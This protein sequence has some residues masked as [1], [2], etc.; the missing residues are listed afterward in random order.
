VGLAEN[1]E[2]CAPVIETSEHIAAA[3]K[4]MREENA[5]YLTAVMEGK[6]TDAYLAH[7]GANAPKFTDA[8]MKAIGSPIDFVGLNN[9]TTTW[10]RADSGPSGYAVVHAPKSYP[11]MMSSWLLV[12]PQGLYWGP[13][14]ISETWGVKEIYITENGASSTDTLTPDGHVYDSDR[15]MYL[16]NYLTQLYRGVSEGV[17]V[18]GYFCWSFMDNYEWADGYAYRFG[19]HYVDFKTQRRT[20]KLS[21]HF[22]KE[23]IARNGLA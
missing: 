15:V 2:A 18:K 16:R 20:P 8:D 9:Y 6:Y 1:A 14:L 12:G 10:V 5:G 22:Y 19:L 11:H 17:P 21:A 4:A 7:H 3:R 23:V 13:K